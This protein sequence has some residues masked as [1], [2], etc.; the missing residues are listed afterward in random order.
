[1][2]ANAGIIDSGPGTLSLSAS[3]TNSGT[4]RASTG[5]TILTRHNCATNTGTIPLAGGIF[6]STRTFTNTGLI[7]G[8]GTLS[9][10]GLTNNGSITFTDGP[11]TI[12]G[13]VTNAANQTITVTNQP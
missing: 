10:A 8:F 4:L 9:T 5:G 2:I 7:N 12:I 3:L 6:S 13:N 11:S 1:F